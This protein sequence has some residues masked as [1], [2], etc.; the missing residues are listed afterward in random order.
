MKS[1][2]YR[3]KKL[4]AKICVVLFITIFN[5]EPIDNQENKQSTPITDGVSIIKDLF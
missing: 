4:I 3:F 2:K 5:L 1:I